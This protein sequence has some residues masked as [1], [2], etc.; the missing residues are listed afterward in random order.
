M[1]EV[2]WI[3]RHPKAEDLRVGLISWAGTYLTFEAHKSSVTASA[4]SLG[5]RQTWEI[6]VSNEHETQAVIRLKSL[7][8]LYLLCEAD[9][10]VCYGRPKTSH[11]GCFLLRF[12]R[13]GKWTFQCI[14][15][16]RYLESD[17]EDVFCNSRVLSA[18]HM[19]T[20][21]PALHIH[22]TLYSPTY[23]SYARADHTVGRIWVDAAVPCLEECGFLLHFQDG[24]Y[25]LE[26][27]THHFLSHVDRLVPKRSP[28]TAFHLQ[29]RPRGLVALCDG[30]GGTLYPQGSHLLLG[31]GSTP[32][33][34][35][36]WFVLQHFPTWVSLKSKSRKFL[37]VIYDA[38]VCAASERLTQMSLFQYECDSETPTLQLRSANG[39]YLAQRRHR[40]I[41]ADGHPMESDTF[42]RVNWNCG[43][44]TLQCPN[45]RFLGIASNGLLMANVTI[46]GPNEELGIRFANRPFLILRGRY[47]YVGSSSDHDL[48]KCNMDQPDCIHLLPCRQGIYH[49]QAQ[50]GSFWSITSFGTFRP[51]GKFALNF[52][53]ELQGSSLLTVLAPNGFYLRADR[54]GTLLADSEEITKEC[55]WEF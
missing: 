22:V 29:V 21:R 37:S 16:G 7:Q 20:P 42:F 25:H 52:C 33:K 45:G 28:Q 51:W 31:L 24:C 46:P 13:N 40:T 43:K 8:G 6:L 27:S 2:D 15:S 4:K 17:G 48:L 34:G 50:G 23:H 39:Y 1:A 9:G 44:I 32:V 19:W 12:H 36:E 11:H 41:I 38:E 54:S 35:E 3:P 55:I 26:T 53:I 10:T 47:G 14:I 18:Y 49:F 30:E 5:R